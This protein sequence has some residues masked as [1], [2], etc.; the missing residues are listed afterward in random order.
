[1]NY[2]VSEEKECWISQ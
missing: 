2:S 1:M